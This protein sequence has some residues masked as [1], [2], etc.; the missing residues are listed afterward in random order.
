MAILKPF[1][2]YS[3]TPHA[4]GSTLSKNLRCIHLLVYPACAGID[5]YFR[6]LIRPKLGLPRMRGDRPTPHHILPDGGGFTPHA[7]G[8]TVSEWRQ[9]VHQQVYPACAGIDPLSPVHIDGRGCLPRMRGDRPVTILR[10][11]MSFKFTP[12]ARGSTQ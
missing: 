3:F 12:H 8:S 10:P 11:D 7:R 5:L 4:R 2:P 6:F 9:Q 1:V